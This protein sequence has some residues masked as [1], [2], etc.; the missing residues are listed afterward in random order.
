MICPS[1]TARLPGLALVGARAVEALARLPIMG[2]DEALTAPLG[3]VEPDLRETLDGQIA[4][5]PG[6]P[7]RVPRFLREVASAFKVTGENA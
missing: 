3:R 7:A 6:T 4:R 1:C 5:L 2:W